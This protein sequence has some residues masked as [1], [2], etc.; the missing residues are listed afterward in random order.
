MCDPDANS[1]VWEL[2]W[3]WLELSVLKIAIF[4]NAIQW[5]SLWKYQF[6][7]RIFLEQQSLLYKWNIFKFRYL[8][9]YSQVLNVLMSWDIIVKNWGDKSSEIFGLASTINSVTCPCCYG[10][11]N[12]KISPKFFILTFLTSILIASIKNMDTTT[13]FWLPCIVAIKMFINSLPTR[14]QIIKILFESGKQV[15]S[16]KVSACVDQVKSDN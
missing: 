1:L 4:A 14:Y 8:Y 12:I 3:Y 16:A 2:S 6:P 13:E 7:I 9:L 10:V 15:K 11:K 5:T